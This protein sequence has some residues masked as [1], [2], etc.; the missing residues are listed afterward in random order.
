MTCIRV[1]GAAYACFAVRCHQTSHTAAPASVF[2]PLGWALHVTDQH[3]PGP[4]SRKS[5]RQPGGVVRGTSDKTEAL[6]SELSGL[7]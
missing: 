2:A 4:R 6:R 7:S 5:T 1:R 3:C